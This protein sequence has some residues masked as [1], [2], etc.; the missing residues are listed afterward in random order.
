MQPMIIV[1]PTYN[2]TSG[3]DSADYGLALQLTDQYHNELVNDLLPAVEA[4]YST[5]AE[6]TTPESLR[7]SRDCRPRSGPRREVFF[8]DKIPHTTN[9]V[10]RIYHFVYL[11]WINYRL[12][13]SFPSP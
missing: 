12:L 1:C 13:T 8:L 10:D 7:A 11:F 2:N 4:R 5:W 3:K 6:T 9:A